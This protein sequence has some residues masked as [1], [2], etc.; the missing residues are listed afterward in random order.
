MRTFRW[1]SLFA[2]F[3]IV[4]MANGAPSSTRELTGDH[5]KNGSG[6]L[7]VNSSGT[8]TTPNA[9][10]QGVGRNTSDTLTNKSISGST[11]T[12]TAIPAGTALSG[13][14]P[15]ANG[16]TAGATK[17]AGFDNLSPLGTAG[18][19]LTYGSGHNSALGT[20]LGDAG[21][22]L[23]SG[24]GTVANSWSSVITPNTL[25]SG[26]L[27]IGASGTAAA[28]SALEVSSTTKGFLLPRMT[29]TQRDAISSPTN[30][31]LIFNTDTAKVNGYDGTIWSE[32]SGGGAFVDFTKGTAPSPPAAG[33]SRAFV[34]TD[35]KPYFEDENGFFTDIGGAHGTVGAREYINN[36]S[37]RYG[38]SGW[39]LYNDSAA[40]PTDMTGGTTTGLAITRT[41]SSG[42]FVSETQGFKLAKDAANRQGL[43]VSTD[44]TLDLGDYE[45]Q[46]PVWFSM[47]YKTSTNYATGDLVCYAYDFATPGT[48]FKIS[49]GATTDAGTLPASS[50]TRQLT[51]YFTPT[52]NTSASYR[53]GCHIAT[54][55]ANAWN[56]FFGKVHAG[57][58]TY[59]FGQPSG[60][61]GEIIAL[62]SATAPVNFILADGTAVSRSTYAELFAII[63]TTYG[64]GDG[65]TTFNLPN[66]QGVFLR[67]AGTQTIS[68]IATP[69][70]TLGATQ[71]DQMQGHKHNWGTN[72]QSSVAG[73]GSPGFFN[74]TMATDPT[75]SPVTD[76]T[77]GTPRTGT[78]TR[79]ANIGV[80][81]FIRYHATSASPV[82][83]NEMVLMT[84]T[85]LS[86]TSSTKTP[87]GSSNYHAFTGNSIVL[88]P[89]TWD[90][91]GSCEYSTVTASAAI[92]QIAC[93]I[94][95]ANGADNGTTPAALSTLSG[96]TV[97]SALSPTANILYG[98]PAVGA[99][100]GLNGTI[101]A[102]A[103][104]ITTT[105]ASTTVY[106]DSFSVQTTSANVRVVATMTA[107]KVLDFTA[108]GLVPGGP[109]TIQK[110]TTGTSQT[111]TTPPGVRYIRVRLIGGGG[112]A[113][114]GT[115]S[116]GGS[117]G[118]GGTSSFGTSLLSGSGGVGAATS[119]GGV[120]GAASLG[121]GPIG[122]AITG[123]NGGYGVSSFTVSGN[124]INASGIG[125][126]GGPLGSFGCGGNGGSAGIVNN[127]Q[128]QSGGGGGA[129]GAVDAIIA[130]PLANY[131]YSVGAAGTAGAA[132]TSGSVG[133]AGG[134]GIIIV[135]E[136][137]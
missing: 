9:T 106:L 72:N 68:G 45:G 17:Q 35:G 6:S 5:V 133:L 40:T 93:G 92:T 76:G 103:T 49:F 20:V 134:G 99:A 32:I 34:N 126:S 107:K 73:S 11:N 29:Q 42:E 24:G 47:L 1:I 88:P 105:A 102:P 19:I 97:R 128:N 137:Y 13:Q 26:T 28:S 64:V 65:S 89:G 8:W 50:V 90:L 27:K 85:P 74:T 55:N 123:Q 12:L 31:L 82:G 37:A 62:G 111:Y 51:G 77:N 116:T 108:I 113:G 70:I 124:V 132:G 101:S 117:G 52:S 122:V 61:V 63:G 118:T 121:T 91:T 2:A 119:G 4:V 110:F 21:K 95:G 129:G 100:T 16:G 81:W 7:N 44:I 33:K 56:V 14:V 41:T 67:G 46:R 130:A 120:G 109:P 104:T 53:L 18:D 80:N 38:T 54:T 84:P 114:S 87:A 43:G 39:N 48:A 115:G 60:P 94:F 25:V 125:A 57:S 59:T 36:P 136:Y 131:T 66:G 86:A 83:T 15:I 79:P 135:E 58:I 3:V 10:D 78:E 98:V 22:F 23:V 127:V 71:G 75:G 69:T 96:V 30:G 112:G